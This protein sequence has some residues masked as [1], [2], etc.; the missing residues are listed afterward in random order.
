MMRAG[1]SV[2][3][4]G[5]D[6]RFEGVGEAAGPNYR[7]ERGRFTVTRHG[8][9]IATLTPERRFYPVER[10]QTTEAAI[11]TTWLADLYA[12]VGDGDGS[13][14][15]AVR[16]YHNPLVPW[17]WGGAIITALGGAL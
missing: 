10:Q 4:A 1:D 15:Y 14:G 13:G 11:H 12:V 9:A 5:Y 17:I 6:F 16:L 7:A 3:M 2:S 8:R